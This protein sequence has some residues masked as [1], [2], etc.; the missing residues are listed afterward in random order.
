MRTAGVLRALRRHFPASHYVL[1]ALVFFTG[2][3][4]TFLLQQWII[5]SL[6][7]LF[8]LVTAGVLFIRREESEDFHF[9]QGILPVLSAIGL[10]A[11]ALFLPA[12]ALLHLYFLG[13][14]LLFYFLLQ[15]GGKQAYPTWNWGITAA[16][17]FVDVA[18]VLG[19]HFHVARSLLVTLFLVWLIIFLLAWQALRRVPRAEAEALLLSLCLAFVLTEIAWALQFTPLHFFIQAGIVVTTYYLIFEILS[20]SFAAALTQRDVVE[21]AVVGSVALGLLLTAAQ[22]L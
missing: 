2:L 18:A 3:E 17:L 10:T 6:V 9:T 21:Y 22:W 16:T 8:G 7:V 14:S 4:L 13:A 11:F 15:F 1:L 19:W 5:I 12:S 20:R